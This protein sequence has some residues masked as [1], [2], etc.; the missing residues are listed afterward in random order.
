[1]RIICKRS[2]KFH[3]HLT[4]VCCRVNRRI[5]RT[6]RSPDKLMKMIQY[7]GR[8]YDND[9]EGADEF[10]IFQEALDSVD[11]NVSTGIFNARARLQMLAPNCEDLIL[12]CKWGGNFFNCSDMIQYRATS[13]GNNN[14]S[15]SN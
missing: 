13:E 1:M 11:S 9:I 3:N 7:L 8:L 4:R 2:E 6:Y 5:S 10:S 15:L 12:K 14:F